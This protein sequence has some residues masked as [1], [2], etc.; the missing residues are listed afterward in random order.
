VSDTDLDRAGPGAG[1]AAPGGGSRE[2]LSAWDGTSVDEL[3]AGWGVPLVEAYA[4]IGSTNDRAAEL[5]AT[6]AAAYA[7]VLADEQTAGRGRRGARWWSPSGHGLLMSVVVPSGVGTAG[8]PVVAPSGAGAAGGAAGT[9]LPLVVGLSVAEAVER[10]VPEAD[11]RVKWPNDLLLGGRKLGGVLCEASGDTVVVGIGLNLRRPAA[12]GPD[13]VMEF[14]TSLEEEGFNMLLRKDLAAEV[15]GR[16]R[17]RI[18][19]GAG[20]LTPEA[21]AALGARDALLDRRL[22]TPEHGEGWGRGIERDGALLLELPDG[23]RVRVVAGSVSLV[24][25]GSR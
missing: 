5:A 3:A 23:T 10:L 22:R 1:G 9:C 18:E 7:V 25:S 4:S 16:I 19:E 11:V 14:A 2:R 17:A 6:G 8:V 12:T 15:L 13:P 20:A 21:H 24:G